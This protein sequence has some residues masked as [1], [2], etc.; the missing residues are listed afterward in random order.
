MKLDLKFL[1]FAF[2]LAFLFES[3]TAPATSSYSISSYSRG[4][5][6]QSRTVS[7]SAKKTGNKYIRAHRN[8]NKRSGI[9]RDN[10]GFVHFC[11]Q[12][13]SSLPSIH[14]NKSI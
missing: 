3:S 4:E 12:M 8:W 1:A 10:N 6:L 13:M 7:P 14:L 5:P 11:N 2:S 9:S